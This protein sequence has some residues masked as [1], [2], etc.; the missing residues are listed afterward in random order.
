MNLWKY[1]FLYLHLIYSWGPGL[2][3]NIIIIVSKWSIAI[4]TI[5]DSW[6]YVELKKKHKEDVKEQSRV[7]NALYV[8]CLLKS[9]SPHHQKT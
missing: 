7:V 1:I 6:R 4:M 8:L 3:A 2:P 5:C 9:D